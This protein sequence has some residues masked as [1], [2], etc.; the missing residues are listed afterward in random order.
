M[1]VVPRNKVPQIE[2]YEA[3]VAKWAQHPAEI[4]PRCA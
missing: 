1:R 4:G 2:F 3:R